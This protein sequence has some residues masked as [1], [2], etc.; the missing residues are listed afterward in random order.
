M[1]PLRPGRLE[2]VV[3]ARSTDRGDRKSDPFC[4]T[5]SLALGYATIQPIKCGYRRACLTE[6]LTWFHTDTDVRVVHLNATLEGARMYQSAGF[7]EPAFPSMRLLLERP[8]ES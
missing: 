8:A 7:R 4:E 5:G 6:L 3:L 1:S 2:P